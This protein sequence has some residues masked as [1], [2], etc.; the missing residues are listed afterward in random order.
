M[1]NELILPLVMF[2][3][4]ILPLIVFN[5]LILPL[6]MFNELILPLIVFAGTSSCTCASWTSSQFIVDILP[7]APCSHLF[8]Q[9]T[10]VITLAQHCI[11]LM[12]T[13]KSVCLTDRNG[14]F[15]IMYVKVW[16]LR[17]EPY[18]AHLCACSPYCPALSVPLYR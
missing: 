18:C 6:V 16:L 2:N 10:A 1:F 14:Y 15:S 4:L 13:Q 7:Q 5:D 17:G 12:H 8:W 9:T 11:A 3:D